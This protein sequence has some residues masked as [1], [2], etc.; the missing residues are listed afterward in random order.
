MASKKFLF[1]GVT[2]LV[3]L[4]I[5]DPSFAPTLLPDFSE[6]PSDRDDEFEEDINHTSC[7]PLGTFLTPTGLDP[8]SQINRL[9]KLCMSELMN[10]HIEQALPYFVSLETSDPQTIG[11]RSKDQIFTVILDLDETLVSARSGGRIRIR[12]FARNLLRYLTQLRKVEIIIWTAGERKHAINALYA[13]GRGPRG[14]GF[15][16]DRLIY[17]G[18]SWMPML[19]EYYRKDLCLLHRTNAILIENTRH[20]AESCH[21]PAILVPNFMGAPDSVLANLAR[22]V[23]LV[24]FSLNDASLEADSLDIS[25]DYLSLFFRMTGEL[26]HLDL[27]FFDSGH[28]HCE[29]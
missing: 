15:K 3:F 6:A 22:I 8:L 5:H 18:T 2:F 20:I 1:L 10:L 26:S 4:F 13:L 23:K 11:E 7:A 25:T 9:G 16:I 21:G 29:L 12:P 27:E 19:G 28:Y 24:V 17:R 14:A